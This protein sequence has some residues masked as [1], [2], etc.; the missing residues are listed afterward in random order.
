MSKEQQAVDSTKSKRHRSPNYPAVGLRDA[1]ERVRKLYDSEKKAGAPLEV[2][3][4][5]I[6]FTVAHGSAMAVLAAL[7]KFGL[8][9]D[10]NGRIVPTSEAIEL[11]AYGEDSERGLMALRRAALKPTVYSELY[12]KYK[13]T[14]MP[15]DASLMAEL[16]ADMGFNPNAVEGFVRDFRDTLVY[17]RLLTEDG[18]FSMQDSTEDPKEEKPEVSHTETLKKQIIEKTAALYEATMLNEDVFTLEQGTVT[19]KW[20][21]VLSEA[22]YQDLEDWL[23]LIKRKA[24][25]AV[26]SKYEQPRRGSLSDVHKREEDE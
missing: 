21:K 15:S 10:I 2:A 5:R 12:E 22:S 3:I 25:R 26:Q 24:K 1:V 11:L 18:V 20:P 17:S 4:K 6:G 9:D 19:I 13:D 14:G 23:E 8:V 16:K 7:K